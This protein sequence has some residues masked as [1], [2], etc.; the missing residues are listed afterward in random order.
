MVANLANVIQLYC[1]YLKIQFS[2]SN[3]SSL[4]N[5]LCFPL[6][7]RMT[8]SAVRLPPDIGS[9]VPQTIFLIGSRSLFCPFSLSWL[10][11]HCQEG[12]GHQARVHHRTHHRNIFGYTQFPI[13]AWLSTHQKQWSY[14]PANNAVGF[15]ASARALWAISNPLSWLKAP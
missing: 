9:K 12:G 13:P 10:G 11:C 3:N 14:W 4:I 15:G 8:I 7:C 2:N 5:T 1:R 6:D